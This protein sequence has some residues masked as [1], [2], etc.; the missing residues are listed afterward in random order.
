MS[1]SG[2][3]LLSADSATRSFELGLQ[4]TS[5]FPENLE[6]LTSLEE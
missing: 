5:V 3:R 4:L 6:Q 2:H 1:Y